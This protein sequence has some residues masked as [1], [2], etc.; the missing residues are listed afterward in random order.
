MTHSEMKTMANRIK[1]RRTAM[2]FTQE[3][4]AEKI[5]LSASSYTKIENAWQKPSLDTLIR[6][7]K[8]L[9]TTL[10]YLVCGDNEPYMVDDADVLRVIMG[11]VDTAQLEHTKD[12]LARIINAKNR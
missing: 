6:I 8:L 4:F 1:E 7:A 2:G 3:G 10:D 11:D 5:N 9:N 12:I